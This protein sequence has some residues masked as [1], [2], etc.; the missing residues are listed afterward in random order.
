MVSVGSVPWKA[1]R[2][3]IAHAH[4]SMKAAF[5]VLPY[6]DGEEQN[7]FDVSLGRDYSSAEGE[8]VARELREAR[9]MERLCEGQNT[10]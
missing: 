10:P 8:Q 1:W 4:L 5:R 6:I 9:G 3:P 2:R 7:Y